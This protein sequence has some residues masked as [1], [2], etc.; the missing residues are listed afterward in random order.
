MAS[1]RQEFT[2]GDCERACAVLAAVRRRDALAAWDEYCATG[3]HTKEE[4]IDVWMAKL[5]AGKDA[6]PPESHG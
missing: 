6:E 3:L 1:C 4:A 2:E 5:E